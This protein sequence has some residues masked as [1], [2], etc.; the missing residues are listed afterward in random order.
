MKAWYLLNFLAP[1]YSYLTCSAQFHIERYHLSPILNEISG[2]EKINDTLL[3]AINDG[4]NE[5]CLYFLNFKGEILHTSF[6]KNAKNYD[7]ED[8]TIDQTNNLY[9]ADCGNNLHQRKQFNLHKINALLALDR[10]TIN[11]NELTFSY[12]A[13]NSIHDSLNFDCEAIFWNN[14]TLFFIP[15]D[16]FCAENSLTTFSMDLQQK[17]TVATP[18][19]SYKLNNPKKLMRRHTAAAI[20]GDTLAVLSYSRVNFLIAPFSENPRME[21]VKLRGLKQ[22]EAIVFASS[23]LLFIAAEKHWLFGGPYL[24][25]LEKK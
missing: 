17:N 14:D 9:I 23:K 7:W 1:F 16:H 24:Y 15:K 22:R 5:P 20:Y 11:S 4:G 8:L 19:Y 6:L 12:A 2:L 13:K 10:D 21:T 18:S 3:A 25:V